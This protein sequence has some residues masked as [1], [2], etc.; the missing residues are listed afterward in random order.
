MTNYKIE[1]RRL[2][3]RGREFHFVS[4]DGQPPNPA[5]NQPGTR[6]AWFLMNAGKRW[7]VMPHR[8][9]LEPEELDQRLI[10]WLEEKVFSRRRS[11]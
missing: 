6:P 2:T 10:Q 8:P 5:R 11:S 7:K 9:G 1:Q 3:H 4:Y